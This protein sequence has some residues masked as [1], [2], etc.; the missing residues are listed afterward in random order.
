M[1]E[2]MKLHVLGAGGVGKIDRAARQILANTGVLVPHERMLGLFERAGAQVDRT[3]QRVRIPGA[4]LDDCIRQA[5][6]SF[7][8]YGRDRNI[9]A[10]FGQGCRNY[11]SIAGEA[12][13][14]DLDGR[15]RFATMQDVVNAAKLGQM[16]PRLN[17]VGAMSDP[18]EVEVSHRVVEVVANQLRTTTK[19]ITFWFHDGPSAKY[20]VEVMAAVAGGEKELAKFP[21]AYPFLEPISPLRFARWGIDVLFETSKIPLPV[22]IGPMAQVGMSAP[23]TLAGTVAQET[24]EVLA[25]VCVVQLIHP[26]TPVCFG[27]ICHAFDMRTTQMI[28]S[29]PEQGLMAIATTEMG[30]HYGLP[31]YINVGLTDSKTVDAQAGMECM[32]SLLMGASAGADIFGHMGIS[33]VDQAGSLEML[34]FQHEVI[35]YVERAM[36]GFA[37]DDEHLGLD[38]IDEVAKSN[39]VFIDQEHTVRHFRQEVW[40]PTILDREYWQ[41]WE[42]LG[43]PDTARRVREK[44]Q[45]LMAAYTPCPL[46]DTTE[47]EV[48]KIIAAAKGA[49]A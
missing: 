29:G 46:D 39:G 41:Q 3:T 12:S 6:K 19:P 26:G 2:Q 11:N 15:R 31:V 48:R 27:G 33:G 22:S 45:A 35:E 4:L 14:L 38:L 16:L 32:G 44:Y 7:T 5:G 49:L 20:V 42:A 25:G 13:W 37:I 30:K 10:R 47:K 34:I 43:R 36:R 8:L 18:H 23:G 9:T 28:F 17:I 24:A 1:S 21:L 40:V